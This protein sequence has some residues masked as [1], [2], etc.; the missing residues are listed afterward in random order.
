MVDTGLPVSFLECA[1]RRY[2]KI[3]HR[4]HPDTEPFSQALPFNFYV[5]PNEFRK[6][7]PCT[8]ALRRSS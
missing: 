8:F 5:Q 1:E 2:P 4:H 6:F 7:Q 3:N